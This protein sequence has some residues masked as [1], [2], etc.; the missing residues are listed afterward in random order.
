MAEQRRSRGIQAARSLIRQLLRIARRAPSISQPSAV[1]LAGWKDESFNI[2][3]HVMYYIITSIRDPCPTVVSPKEDPYFTMTSP[4]ENHSFTIISPS[5]DI[6]Q[7]TRL[8][9][10]QKT[11]T[12]LLPLC[13]S[14]QDY[15]YAILNTSRR[16]SRPQCYRNSALRPFTANSHTKIQ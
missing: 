7:K 4:T 3:K 15:Y 12:M 5:P 9:Y 16:L 1:M 14:P 6:H 8:C 10:S 2:Y 13:Y 11:T